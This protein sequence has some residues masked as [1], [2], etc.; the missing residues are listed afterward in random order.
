MKISEA[1][2]YTGATIGFAGAA[3]GSVVFPVVCTQMDSQMIGTCLSVVT[4]FT[5]VT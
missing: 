4:G 5:V 2:A 1:C 3:A